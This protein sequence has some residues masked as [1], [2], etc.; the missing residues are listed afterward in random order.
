MMVSRSAY[1]RIAKLFRLVNDYN[2]PR[3]I[4]ISLGNFRET[5][6]VLATLP[7]DFFDI[8]NYIDMI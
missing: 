8:C 1:P 7:M 3:N 4:E 2:I 6:G 5:M